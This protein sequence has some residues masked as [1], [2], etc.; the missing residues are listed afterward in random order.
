[1]S[2]ATILSNNDRAVLGALFDP[3]ASLD[4]DCTTNI[5]HDTIDLPS[6]GIHDTVVAREQQAIAL[7]DSPSPSQQDVESAIIRFTDL[8]TAHPYYASAY[9][10]RAQAYRLLPNSET[11]SSILYNI[12]L[13]LEQAI[14]VAT[15]PSPLS[16]VGA[17]HA[18]VLASAHTHRGYLLL[19]A[20]TSPAFL[21]LLKS[22]RLPSLFNTTTPAEFEELASADF[23]VAGRYGNKT[24]R[25]L[26]VRTNPYAK[27]CGQ[28]VKEA[29][30]R[31]I[32]TYYEGMRVVD[33]A[34]G[35]V[36]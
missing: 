13:D 3:E 35:A 36:R 29:L 21:E 1:M 25:D 23:A 22:L 9:N 34:D 12:L 15:R 20:S 14:S 30:Q 33:S 7:V 27:L 8:T 31:E 19:R 2:S 28:I 11:D 26:A 24:A 4:R 17:H 18:R 10:N 32:K 16:P 6:N 5:Q